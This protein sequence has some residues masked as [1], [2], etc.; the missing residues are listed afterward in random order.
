MR[1]VRYDPTGGIEA[2]T[3]E[4]APAPEPGPGQVLVRVLASCINPGSLSA[5]EGAPYVPGRDLAGE[6]AGLGPGTDAFRV[7]QAVLGFCQDWAAHAEFVAVP[8]DQ[9]VAKPAELDWDVAGSLY[10]T[11]MAGLGSV[12]AVAPGPGEV[13]VVA[14][15]SGGVGLVACQLARRR[16]ATVIGL[17]GARHHDL[18]TGLGVTPV[19]YGEGQQDRIRDA[20]AGTP[21]SALLDCYGSG[22]VELALA[23]GVPAAR[24]N[25]VADFSAARDHGVQTQGTREAGGT[26]ALTDLAELAAHG[27][28]VIPI[29]S[30]FPLEEVIQAHHRVTEPTTGRVVLHPQQ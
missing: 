14:G 25:T 9:L 18:L 7:G 4:Q 11:P 16:G 13:V 15:A 20:A 29:D 8:A 24:I 21:V 22:Y 28:L 12:L 10:T 26:T 19:A 5:L 1:I 3:V 30:T 17:A 27:E 6:V 2:I 23:L